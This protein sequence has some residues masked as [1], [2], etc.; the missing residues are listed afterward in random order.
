[1]VNIT[2]ITGNFT[3]NLAEGYMNIRCKFDGGKQINRSQLGSWEG[4]CA[5]AAL[6]VNEGPEWGP[7]C[8]EK[9][10]NS[11][12]NK[13]YKAVSTNWT[14]QLT[15][16]KKRKAREDVKLKRKHQKTKHSSAQGRFDYSH[17]D[18][19]GPNASEVPMDLSIDNLHDIMIKYYKANIMVTEVS[20]EKININTMGQSIG[21]FEQRWHEERRKRITASNVGQIA[22]RKPTTK[23][24]SKVKQL[25]YSKFHGNRATDWGLLQEDVSRTEYLKVKQAI[26]PEFSLANSGLVVSV[27][28]PWLAASPDGLVYDPKADPPQGLVE[29]K[30]PYSVRGK[31]LEEAATSCKTFCLTINNDGKLQLKR[32]H[33]YYYQIQ[34]ALFCTSRK[35]SDLVVLTKSLHIERISAD[36]NFTSK[37]LPK[38]RKFYFTAILPE[39]ACPQAVIRE[40]SQWMTEEWEKTYISLATHHTVQLQTAPDT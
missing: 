9:V 16:D 14:K 2:H 30:N 8:W 25:L 15:K 40:P 12:N 27:A 7:I 11:V 6:R 26:S 32:G 5:G 29:F 36:L 21:E 19:K 1:M 31:T 37:I 24:V 23:V 3:T 13:T 4:R 33:D 22:K 10:T 34:C 20:A 35:W 39:L 28:N 17:Y 18:N 38:L